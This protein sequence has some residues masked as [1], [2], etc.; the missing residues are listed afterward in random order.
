MEAIKRQIAIGDIH[1][2]HSLVVDLIEEVIRFDPDTDQ[3]IFIGDYIDRGDKSM[4]VV[5]YIVS[6]K[7]KYPENIVLLMGNHELL[8]HSAFKT[9]YSNHIQLWFINGG[10]NTINSFGN[11]ANAQRLLMPFI[12]T[13]LYYYETDSHIF[14]HGGIPMAETLHS[15]QPKALLWDRN[16]DRYRGK[17]IIVGHT[18]HKTVTKYKNAIVI[19]TG[20]VYTGRLSAYDAINDCTYEAVDLDGRQSTI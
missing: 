8:A 3:L 13:L 10:I 5:N 6:L 12:D 7:N 17:P 1:G 18:P 9:R 14:V 16:Y 2:C 4:H 11:Y 15:A 20:A 19:D